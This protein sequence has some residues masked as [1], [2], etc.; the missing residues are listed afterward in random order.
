MST[1]NKR[2]KTNH[3]RSPVQPVRSLD[4]FFGKQR[5]KQKEVKEEP[6]HDA[7]PEGSGSDVQ[8]EEAEL[9]DEQL[10]RK[11]QDEWDEEERQ[12]QQKQAQDQPPPKGTVDEDGDAARNEETH[13]EQG[14]AKVKVKEEEQPDNTNN[15][16]AAMGK[17]NTLSLQSAT[18]EEDTISHDIP[19]DESP[20]AFDPQKYIPEL[21]KQWAPEAQRHASRP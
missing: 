1:P 5:E 21:K 20:L 9:T 7:V 15:A 16:F 4:F 18:A 10:A 14:V 19:F 2:R 17:K 12:R 3:H 6:E 8:A 13:G 11:L